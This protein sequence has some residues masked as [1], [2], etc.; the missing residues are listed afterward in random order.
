[1]LAVT[2]TVENS[3]A[4]DIYNQLK[5]ISGGKLLDVGT[6][7]GTFIQT[8]ARSLKDFDSFIGI[9]ISGEHIAVAKEKFPDM[10][11]S[12]QIMNAEK[13]EFSDHSFDTVCISYSIHHLENPTDVL[14]E[15]HRVLRPGGTFILQEMFCDG[16]Q[17]DAQRMDTLVHHWDAKIDSQLGIPHFETLS[18][19]Q[20]RDLVGSLNFSHIDFYEATRDV[21]CLFCEEMQKC[22]NPLNPVIVADTIKQI[23][24]NLEK[25]ADQTNYEELQQEAEAL[26][27]RLRM[28][29]TSSASILFFICSK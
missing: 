26:K 5:M 28:T 17:S 21:G 3:G 1:M 16:N 6:Q 13:L 12:F 10:P 2:P 24:D 8:L 15:M 11:V 29:G 18:R 20:I 7:E 27:G 9:D 4:V 23:D 14:Q 25:M 22:E 19:I